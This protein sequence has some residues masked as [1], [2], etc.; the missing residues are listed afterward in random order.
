MGIPNIRKDARDKVRINGVLDP[1]RRIG[2]GHQM[3]V[4]SLHFKV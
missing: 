1:C 4:N 2:G 3:K